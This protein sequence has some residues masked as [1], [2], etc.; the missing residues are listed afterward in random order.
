MTQTNRAF[1]KAYRTDEPQPTPASPT[2]SAAARPLSVEAI[3]RNE[4]NQ[5]S[6][7]STAERSALYG[8][9]PAVPSRIPGAASGEKRP[10][11][12]FI[13]STGIARLSDS[14][15]GDFFRPG[16]TVASFH[17]PE[18]CR[19]L[20][21]QCGAD[22]A[23]IADLLVTNAAAGRSLIGLLALRPGLGAT[24]ITLSLAARLAER[25]R[26]VIVVDGNFRTPCMAK[27]LEAEPTSGWQ[28][29]LKHGAPLTDAAIRATDDRIDL[30]ALGEK[31]P[32]DALKLVSGLQAVV[33]AGVLR[34]AYDHVL[35]DAGA[36]LSKSS[37]P[38][39]VELLRNMGID[40][41]IAVTGPRLNESAEVSALA[42]QLARIGCEF[43]GTI[44]N[45]A[46]V[47]NSSVGQFGHEY[48]AAR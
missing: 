36:F 21:R 15:E 13:A 11:S 33:T 2:I 18:V 38:V 22:L 46:L 24:T 39:A 1:I 45:R 31:I 4:R 35:I 9:R 29:V 3:A 43:L 6:S 30:L 19:K 23:R 10:L 12:S 20:A 34:H 28:D 5:T 26:R 48:N 17:W 44:E 32:N 37:Q 47:Y 42:D 7:I 25:R 14:A 16:T 27:W 41:V 8:P 40:S